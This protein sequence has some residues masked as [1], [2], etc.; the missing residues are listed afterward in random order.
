[1]RVRAVETELEWVLSGPQISK[2]K[3]RMA[4]QG[5]N[6]RKWKTN[7]QRLKERIGLIERP[8]TKQEMVRRL[9]DED[10]CAES[11]LESQGERQGERFWVLYGIVIQTPSTLVLCISQKSLKISNPPSVMF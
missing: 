6:L 2:A 7:C 3:V 10:T 11:K 5:F 4:K 9:E 1:M 8:K